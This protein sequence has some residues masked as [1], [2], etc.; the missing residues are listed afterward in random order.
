MLEIA[1]EA[2][3]R[4]ESNTTNSFVDVDVKAK[5]SQKEVDRV[6]LKMAALSMSSSQDSKTSA[7]KALLQEVP[8]RLIVF[9]TECKIA[10]APFRIPEFLDQLMGWRS[11]CLPTR[12]LKRHFFVSPEM[13]SQ[14]A[15][16]FR[17]I[18]FHPVAEPLRLFRLTCSKPQNTTFTFV[19]KVVDAI[20]IH[21]RFCSESQLLFNFHLNPQSLAVKSIL[22]TLVMPRHGKETLVRIFVG[23]APGVMD[24]HGVIGSDRAV[25]KAP[26]F[27]A[28]IAFPQPAKGVVLRPEF[29]DGMFT[30]NK[31]A[32]RYGLKHE[33]ESYSVRC[34]H[35]RSSRRPE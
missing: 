19:H 5:T 27:A 11:D 24:A 29:Q 17:I 33:W 23:P 6:S 30:G 2:V 14:C 32:V 21:S 15:Q 1:T 12:R 9:G 25:Q 8:N 31:A 3:G 13:F 10:A 35:S 34:V 20:F 4:R 18:P 26:P 16:L 7:R 28:A 22:V